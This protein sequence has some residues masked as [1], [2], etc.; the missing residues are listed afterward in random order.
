[1]LSPASSVRCSECFDIA[2]I[3]ANKWLDLDYSYRWI[4]EPL[5]KNAVLLKASVA[6]RTIQLK[7]YTKSEEEYYTMRNCEQ[8]HIYCLP[9]D[10]IEIR[11]MTREIG[12]SVSVYWRGKRLTNLQNLFQLSLAHPIAGLINGNQMKLACHVIRLK[13]MS[14]MCLRVY[15]RVYRMRSFRYKIYVCFHQL[16]DRYTVR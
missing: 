2:R 5:G 16:S 14:S 3:N 7:Y 13:Q 1:M 12:M 11:R 6:N 15:V 10:W 4:K 8:C 9:C